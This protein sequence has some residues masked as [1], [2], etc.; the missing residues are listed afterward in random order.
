MAKN[1]R[2][3]KTYCQGC[4][5]IEILVDTETG[6]NYIYRC[7]GYGGGLTPLLNADGKPVVTPIEK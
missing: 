5:S 1:K 2:F 4:G 7:G 3:I 6:V